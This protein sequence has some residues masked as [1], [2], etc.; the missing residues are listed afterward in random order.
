MWDNRY[1][2]IEELRKMGAQVQVDGRTAF[3]QGID[4]LSGAT[5]RSCDLR[6]GAAVVI[7]GLAAKGT[8]RVE[9]IQ[10]IERGYQD[11]VGKLRALGAD[12]SCVDEPEEPVIRP[13]WIAG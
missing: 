12:I 9:D 11:I 8:T 5:V 3:I 7:A 2:Y 10:F 4:H 1:K 13:S 6:G